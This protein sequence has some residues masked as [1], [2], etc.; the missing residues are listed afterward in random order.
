VEPL[1]TLFV[2]GSLRRGC[3]NHYL[4]DGAETVGDGTIAAALYVR[5]TL[6]MA[7][8]G[9]GV[10]HG[11]T[12]R[13]MTGDHLKVLDRLER[14]PAWYERRIVPVMLE[15]G[16]RID[17]WCYFKASRDPRARLVDHGDYVRF[18]SERR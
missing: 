12:Y 5:G 14:H 16:A 15:G 6:S 2:Y 3:E 7:H 18:L 1:L 10:I 4:L 17:A 8:E 11:E 9:P 13:L